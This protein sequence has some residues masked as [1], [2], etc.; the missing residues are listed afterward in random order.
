[1][2]SYK[3]LLAISAGFSAQ[4]V[5]LKDVTGF[6][7]KCEESGKSWFTSIILAA[8]LVFVHGENFLVVAKRC[9]SQLHPRPRLFMSSEHVLC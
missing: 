8:S 4:V 7:G 1:M 5:A 3:L 6:N 9:G 2:K